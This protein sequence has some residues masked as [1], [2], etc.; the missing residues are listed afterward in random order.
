M[1]IIY[2]SNEGLCIC[3]PTGEIPLLEVIIK[4]LP[5]G[6]QY[7]IIED[8]CVLPTTRLF[9]SA[10]VFNGTNVV[11]DL[12]LSKEISHEIRRKRRDAEFE[13]W[14]RLATVPDMFETAEIQRQLIR[15]KYNAMQE[16]IDN[17]TTTSELIQILG[18]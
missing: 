16:S 7:W 4:D 12:V 5:N 13:K 17:S 1:K 9:R 2:N 3:T 18:E 14:D 8:E 6:V 15:D 11:E 10:W